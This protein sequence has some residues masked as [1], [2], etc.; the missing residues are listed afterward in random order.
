MTSVTVTVSLLWCVQCDQCRPALAP[1]AATSSPCTGEHR[2][3]RSR[4]AVTP[5][6]LEQEPH[7]KP[8][9]T[10]TD[11]KKIKAHSW[12]VCE[13]VVKGAQIIHKGAS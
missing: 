6:P 3:Q 7:R 2:S 9:Q 5:V 11:R 4:R 12:P 13:G 10:Q 8:A 1:S